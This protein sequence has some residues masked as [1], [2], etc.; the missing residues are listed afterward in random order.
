MLNLLS[1]KLTGPACRNRGEFLR[2]LSERRGSLPTAPYATTRYDAPP[3]CYIYRAVRKARQ[4]FIVMGDARRA[5]R[6]WRAHRYKQHANVYND[7]RRYSL[8][9]CCSARRRAVFDL[10]L[11][12]DHDLEAISG[13]RTRR[14]R[15]WSGGW[16]MIL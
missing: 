14:G 11:D 7:G 5:R 6:Q 8:A 2:N 3:R 16:I 15:P 9:P 1:I 4:L 12:L 10:D 13:F